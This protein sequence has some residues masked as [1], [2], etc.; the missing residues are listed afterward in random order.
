MPVSIGR[1]LETVVLKDEMVV[2][3]IL[4]RGVSSWLSKSEFSSAKAGF[5]E[6]GARNN[7]QPR[8]YTSRGKKSSAALYKKA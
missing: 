5:K 2:V 7:A 4:L 8:D 6:G 1:V 3:E